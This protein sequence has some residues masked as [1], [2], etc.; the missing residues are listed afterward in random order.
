MGHRQ[1]TTRRSAIFAVPLPSLRTT[2]GNHSIGIKKMQQTAL[3]KP[4]LQPRSV[5]VGALTL[6]M[7]AQRSCWV[8]SAP[9]ALP[10]DGVTQLPVH[11]RLTP[12]LGHINLHPASVGFSHFCFAH[13]RKC[14]KCKCW[15]YGAFKKCRVSLGLYTKNQQN[16]RCPSAD[17]RIFM[18]WAR[19][20]MGKGTTILS[21][22][23]QQDGFDKEQSGD[24]ERGGV[25]RVNICQSSRPDSPESLLNMSDQ[26]LWESC[27][28]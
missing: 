12:P 28:C 18:L 4:S 7:P 21:T 16:N 13:R 15:L 8:P 17:Q 6:E 3:N 14:W 27:L 10:Q 19:E 24:E 20:Y 2:Q 11:H 1:Q 25:P 26:K 23:K 22:W 5:L 9:S